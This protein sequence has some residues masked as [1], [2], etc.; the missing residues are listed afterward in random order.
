M[1]QSVMLL[2]IQTR[3]GM[4]ARS[5][6]FFLGYIGLIGC[7]CLLSFVVQFQNSSFV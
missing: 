1:T 6:G 3:F 2:Y 5:N 7:F 4:G